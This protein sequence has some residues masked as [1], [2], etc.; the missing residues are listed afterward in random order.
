MRCISD[1]LY[2]ILPCDETAYAPLGGASPQTVE[3]VS[4]KEKDPPTANDC[5]SLT[6]VDAAPSQPV[7]LLAEKQDY[8]VEA[9]FPH[10]GTCSAAPVAQNEFSSKEAMSN[11][12]P[13][14]VYA[15]CPLNHNVRKILIHKLEK[16]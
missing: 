4:E 12:K 14:H 7:P 10:E 11:D 6:L 13:F 16:S 3:S 9:I 2:E 15:N 1:T 5:T 8:G